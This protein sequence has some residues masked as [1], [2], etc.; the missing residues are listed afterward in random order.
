MGANGGGGGNI[1]TTSVPSSYFLN[2]GDG[3]GNGLC[4]VSKGFN[5]GGVFSAG[6]AR[7][8][9]GGRN[10]GRRSATGKSSGRAR[11]REGRG[12]TASGSTRSAAGGVAS[13][14]GNRQRHVRYRLE[15]DQDRYLVDWEEPARRALKV[16]D[17]FREFCWGKLRSIFYIFLVGGAVSLGEKEGFCDFRRVFEG[18]W[19]FL[20]NFNAKYFLFEI[21]SGIYMRCKKITQNLKL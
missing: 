15:R 8:G 10:S 12:G 21:K 13:S 18:V 4:G 17:D 11:G 5:A 19:V 3:S 1:N 20:Y 2:S 6:S 9:P 16:K 14:R 7:K